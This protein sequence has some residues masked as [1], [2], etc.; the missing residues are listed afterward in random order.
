MKF[1]TSEKAKHYLL[2]AGAVG[3]DV[4]LVMALFALARGLDLEKLILV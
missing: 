2:Y 3:L 4:V 1:L